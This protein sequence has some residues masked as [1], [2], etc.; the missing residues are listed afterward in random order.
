MTASSYHLDQYASAMRAWGAADDTIECRLSFAR[1]L[2]QRWADPG[3]V[4]TADV[5]ELLAGGFSAWTRTTYFNHLHSLFGFL[6]ESGVIERDPTAGIRRP[7]RPK[8]RPR[9]LAPT[10]VARALDA[11]TGDVLAWLL[12]GL[13]AGLRAHEAAKIHASHV[14]EAALY[15]KG[16]GGRE[17]L[18][19]THPEIWSLARERSGYWFPGRAGRVTVRPETV[20]EGVSKL[21]KRLGIA[22]GFHRCRHTYGTDLLRNGANIRVVQRLMR[23]ASLATTEVYLDVTD[24]ECRMAVLGLAA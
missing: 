8:S 12:L 17:D 6:V 14:T 1:Y 2:Q 21:F 23:H 13:R 7:Q 5:T 3:A 10:E 9:P 11:A 20:S 15:V 4:T 18:L 22:G 16:K 19:P 24:D